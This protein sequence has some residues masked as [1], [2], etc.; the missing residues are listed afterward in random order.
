VEE[1][2]LIGTAGKMPAAEV[3]IGQPYAIAAAF[4]AGTALDGEGLNQPLRPRWQL[5]T[6]LSVASCVSTDLFYGFGPATQARAHGLGSTAR[7][8]YDKHVAM[9]TQLVDMEAGQFYA[10]CDYFS[11]PSLR[12][13]AVKGASNEIGAHGQ[14]IAESAAVIRRCFEL[15]VALMGI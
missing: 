12:Y 1:I 6:H 8:L 11:D 5:P 7:Q 10:F 14:Q 3:R 9:G 13:V 2:V 4:L 15:A